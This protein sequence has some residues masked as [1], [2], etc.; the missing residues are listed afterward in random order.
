MIEL[1]HEIEVRASPEQVFDWLGHLREN[2][3][4][5]HP[6]H[7]SCRYLRGEPLQV[8]SVVEIEEL[9]H[10]RPHRIRFRVT[11]VEPNARIR[12][13]IAGLGEGGFATEPLEGG[14][15]FI[16]DL[17]MGTRL[18]VLGALA[19]GVLARLFRRRI[20]A[21]RRHMA[22]EGRNLKRLLETQS[23]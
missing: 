15:V 12:Y 6:D 8:G 14:V 5:W 21:L 10:G 16:A 23:G 20:E 3:L 22:E 1:R 7:R 19:D 17:R 18:P 4:A 11:Q 2:Y 9:L 13:R